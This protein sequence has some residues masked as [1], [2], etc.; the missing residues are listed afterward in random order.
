MNYPKEGDMVQIPPDRPGPKVGLLRKIHLNESY[1]NASKCVVE[2]EKSLIMG[3]RLGDLK[4][5]EVS[6]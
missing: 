1:P 2:R 3:I 5:V 4:K 6:A